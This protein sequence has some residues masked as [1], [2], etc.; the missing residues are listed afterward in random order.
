M[1]KIIVV[2]VV[3]E[4]IAT[5]LC[6]VKFGFFNSF[7]AWFVSM[8]LG[9]VL[10]AIHKLYLIKKAQQNADKHILFT[11][12]YLKAQ[13]FFLIYPG[14]LT[15]LVAYILFIPFI[16]K[17]IQV[18][19]VNLIYNPNFH[20]YVMNYYATRNGSIFKEDHF[21]FKTKDSTVID[22]DCSVVDEHSKEK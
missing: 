5:T 7:L 2:P 14:L 11:V 20:K 6:V 21:A 3:G 12:M 13:K 17:F 16:R 18:K 10:V 22:I 9:L 8:I 15:S 1:L 4:I 19:I